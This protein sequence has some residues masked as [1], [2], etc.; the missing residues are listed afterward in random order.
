MKGIAKNQ[1]GFMKIRRSV[2]T[3]RAI[4]KRKLTAD[5]LVLVEKLV[6]TIEKRTK[7]VEIGP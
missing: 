7:A 5:D 6:T 3:E 4:R 1:Q 2:F